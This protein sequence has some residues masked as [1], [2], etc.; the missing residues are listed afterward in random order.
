MSTPD[1]I[2]LVTG[3]SSGIGRAIAE[4]LLQSGWT[5]IGMSRREVGFD[6]PQ[7]R[8]IQQDLADVREL[9]EVAERDLAPMFRETRWSR[10]GLVNNAA[11]IGSLEPMGQADPQRV[12]EL[13]A[14]NT[15]APMFLMG[16]M[17][18]VAPAAAAL[19]IVNVSTG[20]AVNPF[21]GIG[22][23]GA[24][25]AALRLAGMV[26]AAE[27]GSDKHPGGPRQDAAVLSYA[28]GIV[29]TAMQDA[30]RSSAGPWNDIFVNFHKQGLLQP[31]EK[32]AREILHFLESD[33]AA[34][35]TERR[36]GDP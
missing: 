18:R 7:Y 33:G 36:L 24:S 30:A 6:S 12:L 25:K 22:D 11:L 20:A 27:T 2:A 17:V 1:R 9:R 34:P 23:Y 35:F 19:R 4:L 3:T 14:V 21:P 15:V 10:V 29:D 26:L 13:F 31:P 32:P 28:P 16:L 5:V 8:H